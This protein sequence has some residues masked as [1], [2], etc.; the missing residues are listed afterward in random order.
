MKVVSCAWTQLQ[1]QKLIQSCATAEWELLVRESNGLSCFLFYYLNHCELAV[2]L[3]IFLS[4]SSP[5]VH[6][7]WVLIQVPH[8]LLELW[9]DSER[10][11]NVS[12]RQS[13]KGWK[14]S[15]FMK[16]LC[17]CL[18]LC[19]SLPGW[20]IFLRFNLDDDHRTPSISAAAETYLLLKLLWWQSLSIT[21]FRVLLCCWL[22]PFKSLL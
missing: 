11:C 19:I 15:Q 7:R 8:N 4:P 10:N 1:R 20:Y 6:S 17:M 9:G 14:H 12:W 5:S 13:V 22:Q 18:F 3:A 16:D 2:L 21:C